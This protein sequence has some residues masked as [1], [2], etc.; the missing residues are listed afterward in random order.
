M[1]WLLLFL[2]L[3]TSFADARPRE[4]STDT[5]LYVGPT[6]NNSGNDCEDQNYPCQTIQYAI[7]RALRDW[8]NRGHQIYVK[9]APGRY[10]HGAKIYGPPTGAYIINIV[11][12]QSN[13]TGQGCSLAQANQVTVEGGPG[14]VI[15]DTQD[16]GLSVIRC[17]TVRATCISGPEETCTA[18]ASGVTAFNYR[19]TVVSDIAYI[20]FDNVATGISVVDQGAVNLGG[21]IWVGNNMTVFIQAS[22][23]SRVTIAAPIIILNGVN[24]VYLIL[25][26]EGAHIVFNPG[27]GITN[28]NLIGSAI[29]GLV[30]RGGTIITNGVWLPPAGCQQAD[31]NQP[32]NCW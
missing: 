8:D 17:L 26:Y 24:I 13:D 16:Y 12:Q 25:S 9:L 10:S 4:A 1:K 6:G 32:G 14:E 15:F 2:L 27:F 3:F 23:P 7:D 31:P 22:G 11:G 18:R 29:G 30:Y 20:R 5:W 19:Q 21:T 28:W